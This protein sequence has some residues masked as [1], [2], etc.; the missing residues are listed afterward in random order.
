M[1]PPWMRRPDPRFDHYRES[2]IRSTRPRRMPRAGN[3]GSLGTQA[4]KFSRRLQLAPGLVPPSSWSLSPCIGPEIHW[5]AKLLK[6]PGA[7]AIYLRPAE[8]ARNPS[9][10]RGSLP[11]SS[12]L[13]S[14]DICGISIRPSTPTKIDVKPTRRSRWSQQRGPPAARSTGG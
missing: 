1:V 2:P 12:N 3:K 14:N 11:T 9:V 10:Q 4:G 13:C 6:S 7:E 5:R 8:S